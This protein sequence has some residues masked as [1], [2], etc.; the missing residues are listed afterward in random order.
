M[1]TRHLFA[2]IEASADVLDNLELLK[3]ACWNA[4]VCAGATVLDISSHKFEPQGVTLVALLSESHFSI[5]TWPERGTAAVDLF[6]CGEH[7]EPYAGLMRLLLELG[8]KT[9]SYTITTRGV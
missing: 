6:T 8:G 7:T 4:C 2:T 3:K 9:V 1:I 5:H